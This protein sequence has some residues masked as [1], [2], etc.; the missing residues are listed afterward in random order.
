MTA[1]SR[2]LLPVLLGVVT[3]SL[4]TGDGAAGA[5]S[6]LPAD[7]ASASPTP[8][9]SA[10]PGA[11]AGPG[12]PQAQATPV[13]SAGEM[14]GFEAGGDKIRGYLAH[15]TRPGHHS[16]IVVIHEWWGLNGQIKR[17]ADRLA[18]LG[19]LTLAPDFFRG[20]VA[21][22]PQLAHELA[23]G[24]NEDRAVA[25]IK[26]AVDFLKH[27]DGAQDR[28]V[29]TLGF[30]LGGGYSLQ[31]A[32]RDAD[33][34]ATVMFYGSVETSKEAVMP[35]KAPILGIFGAQDRGIPVEDV[36]KFD[37]ALRAAGKKSLI[38]IYQGV[39][40]AFMNETA[41]NYNKATADNAWARATKF[42]A[43][44]LRPQPKRPSP[45]PRTPPAGT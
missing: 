43:G 10:A 3:L 38:V 39:G 24:L 32:L 26:G 11:P 17:V 30:C 36:K 37:A 18:E 8:S 5:G 31:A 16:A 29:G 4:V 35:L 34:D 40:H 42:L 22:E 45:A 19:F 12:G 14:L 25:I 27:Y 1:A 44:A 41:L 9:G 13:Q 2:V 28:N 15:P 23:R 21:E 33:V 20:K 6:R 7:R